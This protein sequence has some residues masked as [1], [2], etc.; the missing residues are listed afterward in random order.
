M[1]SSAFAVKMSAVENGI[2]RLA[3]KSG[4]VDKATL[5]LLS[6]A[7]MLPVQCLWYRIPNDS[8]VDMLITKFEKFMP[9]AIELIKK[10]GFDALVYTFRSIYTNLYT[11]KGQGRT[12]SLSV[13]SFAEFLTKVEKQG[14][15]AKQVAQKTQKT[16][17]VSN[18]FA[19]LL[20]LAKQLNKFAEQVEQPKVEAQAPQV[21]QVA[22]KTEIKKQGYFSEVSIGELTSGKFDS[23]FIKI[24]VADKNFFGHL[25]GSQN[26]NIVINLTSR[27]VENVAIA[28]IVKAQ[29]Y[30]KAVR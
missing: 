11:A 21:Q 3:A 4:G 26:G 8:K 29:V 1:R 30:T 24:T 2:I 5:A 10:H 13:E 6:E 20:T 22:P 7:Y 12:Y 23:R 9:K 14:V 16:T 27:K 17:I 15:V 18:S 19:N 28:T 25:V